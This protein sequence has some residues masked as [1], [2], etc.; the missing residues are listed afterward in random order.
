MWPR[1]A[2]SEGLSEGGG[3]V[4]VCAC[5]KCVV[6]WIWYRGRTVAPTVSGPGSHHAS[7]PPVQCWSWCRFFLIQN[8]FRVSLSTTENWPWTGK[9]QLQHGTTESLVL[10]F[11]TLTSESGIGCHV[12]ILH[13]PGKSN[14]S[15]I[16]LFKIAG[17]SSERTGQIISRIMLHIFFLFCGK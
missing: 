14:I 8:W 4:P 3:H 6:C 5:G 17:A 13:I 7:F 9:I 15:D 16:V 11:S 2:L 12:Q 1:C 10:E